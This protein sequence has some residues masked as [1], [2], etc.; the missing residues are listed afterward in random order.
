MAENAKVIRI[1]LRVNGGSSSDKE[2]KERKP[3]KSKSLSG[4]LELKGNEIVKKLAG[5][6][7]IA[8]ATQLLSES[9]SIAETLSYNSEEKTSMMLLGMGKK[10]ISSSLVAGGYILGGPIGASVGLAINEFVVNPL[11]TLGGISIKRNLDQT[12]I[13]NRF[14]QT[15]FASSGNLVFDYSNNIY[16]NES[17]DKAYKGT[18]YKR[19]DVR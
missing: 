10:A 8:F 12:R 18:C 9:F 16:I 7:S 11:S 4:R 15:N 3:A 19:K 17:L 5:A 13:T 1:Q 14:Y 6:G 2:K